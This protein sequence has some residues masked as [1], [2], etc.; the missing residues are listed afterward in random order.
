[1]LAEPIDADDPLLEGLSDERRRDLRRVRPLPV[2]VE[3]HLGGPLGDDD[4]G[5]R[6]WAVL[7][8]VASIPPGSVVI[9]SNLDQ[10]VEG[11]IVRAEGAPA[12]A[13]AEG[14]D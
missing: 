10:L 8:P 2:R 6:D 4:G 13:H 7:D 12:G 3:Y 11:M 9:L 5:E 1:M 14:S